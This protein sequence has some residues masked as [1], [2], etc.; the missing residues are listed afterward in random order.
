MRSR[1]SR[2][3]SFTFLA[4]VL[5]TGCSR[6]SSV[7]DYERLQQQKKTFEETV[8]AVGGKM[9]KKNYKVANREN[10]AW[11]M[12]FANAQ[13]TDDLI[14]SMVGMGYIGEVDFSKSSIT[15]AQL[16]KM[17]ELN[18]LQFT[19]NL[20]LSDTAISDESFSKIKGM[21]AVKTI[22]LKGSKVTKAGAAAF[23]QAYLASPNTIP[24]FKK[25]VIEL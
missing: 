13:V 2:S 15:D 23:K 20:D 7:S 4:L 12:N 24:L 9:E 25:P 11:N 6:Y 5:S 14:E 1:F 18:L 16:L 22:K 21:R 8:A 10:S 19:M 17:D 3:S